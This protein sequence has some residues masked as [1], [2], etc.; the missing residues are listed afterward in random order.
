MI[1]FPDSILRLFTNAI[2]N[3]TVSIADRYSL[4]AALLDRDLQDAEFGAV[5]QLIESIQ[6]T[7]SATVSSLPSRPAP[8]SP[9]PSTHP[10]L[11]PLWGR[12]SGNLRL[13]S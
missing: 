4:M 10:Q 9:T 12:C 3:G 11:I 2:A 13:V 6:S 1:T 7:T 8:Y 5:D